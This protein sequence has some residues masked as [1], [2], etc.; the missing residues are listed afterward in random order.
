MVWFP[1]E[2]EESL[3]GSAQGL[4]SMWK[5][6]GLK[7]YMNKSKAIDDGGREFEEWNHIGW[8]KI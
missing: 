5:R 3:R 1:G 7:E 6:R 2:S 8:W 4:G